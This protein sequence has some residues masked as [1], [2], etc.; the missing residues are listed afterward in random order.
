MQSEA[1]I[2]ALAALLTATAPGLAQSAAPLTESPGDPAAGRSIVTDQTHGLCI[3]CHSGPFEEVPFMGTLGPDLTRVA[4]RMPEAELRQR[5]IDSRAVNPDTIMPP[6][7]STEGLDRV[8]PEWAGGPILTAREV[9]DVV[10][11]LAT[12]DGDTSQ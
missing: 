1:T 12:L 10:A 3:L 2:L 8:G 7:Y 6:Y 4:T 5:V 9:E 11:F